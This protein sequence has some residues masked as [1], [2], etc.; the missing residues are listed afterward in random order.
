MAF[1]ADVFAGLGGF[2]ERYFMYCEDVDI[3]LRAQLAG[4][5]LE[6]ADAKVVHHTQR[7]TLKSLRHLTWHVRSLLRLWRSPAYLQYKKQFMGIN[8]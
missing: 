8:D 2:D 5:R 1:R 3:C 4:Y 6:R 7:R